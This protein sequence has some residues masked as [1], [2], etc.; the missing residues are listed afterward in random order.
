MSSLLEQNVVVIDSIGVPDTGFEIVVYSYDLW[1][2][3][4]N[5]PA[6]IESLTLEVVYPS[7]ADVSD[8]F[9][10]L[11]QAQNGDVLDRQP[12]PV[13]GAAG[14][15][16]IAYL[17]WTRHGND[18]AQSGLFQFQTV[19]SAQQTVWWRGALPDFVLQQQG[20]VV[21]NLYRGSDGS[22]NTAT[23]QN[24]LLTYTPAGI[25]TAITAQLDDLMP[26]LVS[27]P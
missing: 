22:F 4:G 2:V 11:L 20:H 24:I 18:L 13:V 23:I 6:R 27:G 5:I 17:T 19:P 16:S 7:P 15:V 26:I 9:E 1:D 14:Q 12:S 21:L 8:V 10:V 3:P 25:G